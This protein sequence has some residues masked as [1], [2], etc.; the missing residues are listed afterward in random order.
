M[1][2]GG[3]M[4]RMDNDEPRRGS[5]KASPEAEVGWE[6]RDVIIGTL[7]S[8]QPI[9][10]AAGSG[11]RGRRGHRHGAGSPRLVPSRVRALGRGLATD[12]TGMG[13]ERHVQ[14]SPADPG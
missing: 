1:A 13:E 5:R 14:K 3:Q 2:A 7:W 11:S 8:Q 4:I 9:S 6:R 10:G 12:R